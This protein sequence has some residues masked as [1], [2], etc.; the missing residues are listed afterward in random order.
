MSS[1]TLPKPDGKTLYKF[2]KTAL[3]IETD[4]EEVIDVLDKWIAGTLVVPYA[5][6]DL[7][8]RKTTLMAN[9]QPMDNTIPCAACL[10]ACCGFF[11]CDPICT[12]A[13]QVTV[14]K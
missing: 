13:C 14:C 4:Q 1:T 3:L 10:A 2:I 6:E 7:E 11:G 12:A 8:Q 9:T 5:K